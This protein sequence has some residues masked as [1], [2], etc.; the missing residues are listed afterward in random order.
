MP[1]N[2][3]LT[4]LQLCDTCPPETYTTQHAFAFMSSARPVFQSLAQVNDFDH[5]CWWLRE[6][7][8]AGC[9]VVLHVIQPI[10]FRR[11][12]PACRNWASQ[13]TE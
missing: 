6:E 12:W 8:T 2:V 10:M 3:E 13:L 4:A 5:I 7:A 9:V 11:C 1:R